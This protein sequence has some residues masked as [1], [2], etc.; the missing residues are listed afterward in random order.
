MWKN[1]IRDGEFARN[2]EG[3]HKCDSVHLRTLKCE[4]FRCKLTEGN[5]RFNVVNLFFPDAL[6]LL[7]SHWLEE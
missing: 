2:H 1:T 4:V 5:N 7:L 3:K 6:L